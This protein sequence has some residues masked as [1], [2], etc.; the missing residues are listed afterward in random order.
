MSLLGVFFLL[1]ALA[2]AGTRPPWE[3]TAAEGR[4]LFRQN[5]GVCHEINSND[6]GRKFGPSLFRFF[7]NEQTPLSRIKP[8]DAFLIVK[9]KAGGPIMP[10]F[11]GVLGDDQIEKIVFYIRSKQ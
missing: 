11:R 3:R 10:P 1:A 5:C 6:K 9:I 4:V 8:T 7:R 2:P